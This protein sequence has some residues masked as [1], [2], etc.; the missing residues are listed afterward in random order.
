M[1]IGIGYDIHRLVPDRK[2]VLGGVE[3]PFDKGLLGHSDADVLLHAI[4]DAIL[5]A[6]A[7]G[8]LGQHFSDTDPRFS[9]ISSRELLSHIVNLLKEKNLSLCNV[10]T[11]L[12]AQKPKLSPYRDA[13][14][15][16]IAAILGL[17]LDQV[18]VKFRTHE[19]LG[20][21]GREE[22]IA[23]QAVILISN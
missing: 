18:S 10:D 17:S 23:A 8:D 14:R 19:G 20:E 16:N 4:G 6:A 1:R 21:V 5:G 11:N 9:G 22:A 13:I 15:E 2:L 3:I 7:L 12:I